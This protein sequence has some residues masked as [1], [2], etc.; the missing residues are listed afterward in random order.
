MVRLLLLLL[1]VVSFAA[2]LFVGTVNIDIATVIDI[3]CGKGSDGPATYIVLNSRLPAAIAALLGGGALAVAGL[4]MQTSFRNPLAGPSIMGINSGASLGVA[5]VTL[6]F[7]GTFAAVDINLGGELAVMAGALAGSL[8]IMAILILLST[9]LRNDLMLLIAGI[10]IGYLASSLITLLNFNATSEG[11]QNFVM[12]GMGSFRNVPTT[13]ILPFTVMVCAGMAVAVCLVK[14]L[15]LLMLGDD[16][17]RSLGVNVQLTRRLLLLSTGLLAAAATAFCG[18]VSFI[19]LAV[20][21]MARFITSTDSHRRL[22]PATFLTGAIVALLCNI[23]C[24]LPAIIAS[25]PSTTGR[26]LP[27]N[28]VTPLFGV[29]VILYVILRQRHR[30]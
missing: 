7:G 18:P 19:G 5:L 6:L 12:W 27:L 14:P 28:A 21:H 22:L 16:Y 13:R 1:L 26:M 17:A 29:P 11:I 2:N 30:R 3:L 10:L 24:T 23:A 20:P 15:D 4:M 9:I 25:A 8:L